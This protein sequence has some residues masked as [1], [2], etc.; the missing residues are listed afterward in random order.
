M[1]RRN[2]YNDLTL[3]TSIIKYRYNEHDILISLSLPQSDWGSQ[4][5]DQDGNR[6]YNTKEKAY[7]VHQRLLKTTSG[8]RSDKVFYYSLYNI[9]PENQNHLNAIL[10]YNKFVTIYRIEDKLLKAKMHELPTIIQENNWSN[11]IITIHTVAKNAQSMAGILPVFNQD[12]LK[13]IIDVNTID[14]E[15]ISQHIRMMSLCLNGESNLLEEPN[16]NTLN[17]HEAFFLLSKL[18]ENIKITGV[19]H[20]HTIQKILFQT[21]KSGNNYIISYGIKSFFEKLRPICFDIDDGFY[22]KYPPFDKN[23]TNNLIILELQ[24]FFLQWKG[25]QYIG[26]IFPEQDINF[27]YMAMREIQHSTAYIS[28]SLIARL[29]RKDQKALSEMKIKADDGPMLTKYRYN[30]YGDLILSVKSLSDWEASYN[31][32][33]QPSFY[34]TQER[35]HKAYKRKMH[36]QRQRINEHKHQD[37]KINSNLTEKTLIDNNHSN[38]LLTQTTM[39]IFHGKKDRLCENESNKNSETL[40]SSKR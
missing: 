26:P 31:D 19:I 18:N 3:N 1:H 32:Q 21:N 13:E 23:A 39:G 34:Y 5:C 28:N 4:S 6:F 2:L 16:V 9:D 11:Q 40:T 35:A 33:N 8:E 14:N 37:K 25:N 10:A 38:T 24:K 7:K 20:F 22:D 30:Q 27:S 12:I 17:I 15:K 36:L 29:M